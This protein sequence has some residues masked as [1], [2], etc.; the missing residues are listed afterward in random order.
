MGSSGLWKGVS[1][2]EWL[3]YGARNGSHLWVGHVK[4]SACVCVEEEICTREGTQEGTS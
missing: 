2:K 3:L 4:A 1:E